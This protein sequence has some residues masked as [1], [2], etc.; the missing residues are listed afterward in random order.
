MARDC[1]ARAEW[2]GCAGFTL[3]RF[4]NEFNGVWQEAAVCDGSRVLLRRGEDTLPGEGPD[5]SMIS[6]LRIIAPSAVI[7]VGCPPPPGARTPG[8]HRVN[9]IDVYPLLGS[10]QR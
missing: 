6:S 9:A 8:G 2:R 5:G 1:L 4:V 7:A 3:E 10:L